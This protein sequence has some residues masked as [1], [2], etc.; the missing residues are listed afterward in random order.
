MRYINYSGMNV[1]HLSN[2]NGRVETVSNVHDDVSPQDLMVPGQT[3][4]LY[5]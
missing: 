5:L 3:V 4:N 2:I 1:L